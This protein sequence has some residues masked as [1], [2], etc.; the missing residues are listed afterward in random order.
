M[1]LFSCIGIVLINLGGLKNPFLSDEACFDY[2]KLVVETLSEAHKVVF[3]SVENAPRIVGVTSK[4]IAQ[5]LK[6]TFPFMHTVFLLLSLLLTLLLFFSFL[7]LFSL[8]F[9][10]ILPSF[11]SMQGDP[12][13]C[14]KADKE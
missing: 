10:L 1:L 12:S 11:N 6:P 13:V 14:T 3:G 2:A 4:E 7:S 8:S 5:R 9:A